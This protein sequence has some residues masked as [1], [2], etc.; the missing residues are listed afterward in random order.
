MKRK[1]HIGWL[2]YLAAV[3]WLSLGGLSSLFQPDSDIAVYY[4]TLKAFHD[5]AGH[6]HTAAIISI[7]LTLISLW[8]VYA[9]VFGKAFKAI[10]FFRILFFMRIIFEVTGHY[11]ELQ[12]LKAT[13]HTDPIV[14]WVAIGV[15][16]AVVAPSYKAHFDY[17]FHKK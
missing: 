16:I 11:Y 4:A 9:R 3:S 5:P 8:T 13:H 10:L 2:I 17:A 6:F 15:F 14:V 12:F 7:I 1:I